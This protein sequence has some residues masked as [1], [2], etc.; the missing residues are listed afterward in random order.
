VEEYENVALVS[1]M[2][3]FR[4][5]QSETFLLF[6][7]DWFDAFED[8]GKLGGTDECDGFAVA[9]KRHWNSEA[10]GFETLVPK[11]VCGRFS[12]G[13]SPFDKGCHV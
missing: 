4:V 5:F 12:Q 10:T 11:D 7:D 3:L 8:H 13:D 2:I 1:R 9:G 6:D